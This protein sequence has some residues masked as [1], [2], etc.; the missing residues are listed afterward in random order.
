V[1]KSVI[2]TK[3]LIK[4]LENSLRSAFNQPYI[5]LTKQPRK[6]GDFYVQLESGATATTNDGVD[7]TVVEI[8]SRD[9][10][11]TTFYF[12]FVGLFVPAPEKSKY[13]LRHASLSV[14][15]NIIGD[16]IP[17]F[18]ADWD[19]QAASDDTAPHAQPHWHF[20]QNPRNIESILRTLMGTSGQPSEFNP[21]FLFPSLPD[22]ADIH[23]AMTSLGTPGYR[24]VLNSGEFEQWFAGMTAY[25]GSQ[26][27]YIVS[28]KSAPTTTATVVDFVPYQVEA[29]R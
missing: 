29:E 13:Y 2:Y 1:T 4:A 21:G 12:G 16:P 8:L 6:A 17:L 14:F 20:V 18:R 7:Q 26:I 11:G 23:F 10:D 25:V 15:H 22:C 24:V 9:H 3:E 19:E 27:A 5:S 28:K